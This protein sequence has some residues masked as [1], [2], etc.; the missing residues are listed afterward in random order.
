MRRRL[1]KLKLWIA[2]NEPSVL[3]RIAENS[4][5]N[6]TDKLTM[7]DIDRIISAAS[8]KGRKRSKKP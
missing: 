1:A 8:V 7:R 2:I 5:R 3:K 6:R 4:V